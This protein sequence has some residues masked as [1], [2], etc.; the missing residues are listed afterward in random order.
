MTDV[1]SHINGMN[2]VWI[3]KPAGKSRGRGIRLFNKV[4]ELLAYVKGV[5][6]D[7]LHGKLPLFLHRLLDVLLPILLTACPIN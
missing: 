4:D 6:Y 3:V 5:E 7:S 2:N 1:Q